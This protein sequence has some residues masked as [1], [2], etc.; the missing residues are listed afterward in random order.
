MSP[1]WIYML[2]VNVA[3]A[4]F[5]AFY[6]LFCCKDTFFQWRRM[7][8]MGFLGVSFLYPFFDIQQWMQEQTPIN[9]L[10]QSYATWIALNDITVVDE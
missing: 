6:K 3:I 9:E 8:L 1:E 4:L 5:Y 2:K 7:A 10:A